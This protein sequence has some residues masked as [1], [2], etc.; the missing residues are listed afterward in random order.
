VE[1]VQRIGY[2]LTPADPKAASSAAERYETDERAQWRRFLI[3]TIL[4]LPA[5][6]LAMAV[7]AE[8]GGMSM[9]GAWIQAILVA[10]VVFWAGWQF[11]AMAGRQLKVGAVGMDT[12]ISL[13]TLTA[14]GWS[15]WALLNGGDVFFETA[16]IIVTLVTLGRAFE[17]RAKGR[18][19]RAVTALLELGAREA[20]VVTPA[21]D[22]LLAIDQVMPGD[23]MVV[24]PGERVPTD[25]VVVEGASSFDESMLTGEANPVVRGNGDPVIGAT[26]NQHGKVLVRATK[27]G[28]ETVLAGIVRLVES[29]QEGKAPVQR[30]A[31]RISAVFVPIVILVAIG[32]LA[33][34][35]LAGNPSNGIEAAIAVLII[36]CPC[37]LGLATPTAIM[38]GSGR[39][40]ELGILFKNP[41]VFERARN[42]DTVLFDK[43]GTLTTGAMTLIDVATDEDPATFLRLAAGV[44]VSGG[45]PI[46]KAVALGAEERGLVVP[47]AS[48]VK[49]SPGNGVAGRVEGHEVLVGRPTWV[50]KELSQQIPES[51]QT[52][53]KR[54]QEEGKSISMVAW[55]GRI[56]GGMA[57][58]DRLRPSAPAAVNDLRRLD[59][60][61]A[62]IS[63]DVQGTARAVGTEA[64]I[65]RVLAEVL[66]GDKAKEIQA[67]QAEGQSVAFV[68]DG[69]NDA[70]AL[71]QADLGIAVGTGSDIAIEAGD[72]VVLSGDPA[73]IPVAVRLARRTLRTIKQNLFWAF[74]YNVAAIP[75]AALGL[76]EPMIAAAAMAFS[77]VSVVTNSLRLRAFRSA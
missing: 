55:D 23:V 62:M 15:L 42:V 75:L 12:L 52:A 8:T 40:A 74:A 22:R 71:T 24:L 21:G 13:G 58:A 70:P 14:Y 25:G 30:L 27:V 61:V 57:I 20:R 18:A 50:A 66:P 1:A 4:S 45:H 43:T 72:V 51:L 26:V 28:A 65:D 32:T 36:A 33:A 34:W 49:A 73:Q 77:S 31:D 41:E 5:V 2:D 19:S 56:R 29:A 35:A 3:A 37:A 17:T 39:G 64:G 10:P 76:L 67:L 47:A 6:V 69:I 54:W 11:H 46:G 7:P 9:T 38:V 53:F 59:L 16:A 60:Q 68:G 63:G 48:A 44:D